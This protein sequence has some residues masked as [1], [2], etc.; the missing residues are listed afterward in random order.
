MVRHQQLGGGEEE[1]G[2]GGVMVRH[3][4]FGGGGGRWS[5]SISGKTTDVAISAKRKVKRFDS[6]QP[7]PTSQTDNSVFKRALS[8]KTSN[9]AN[10]H[11][12]VDLRQVLK[13]Q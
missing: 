13:I 6:N 8:K 9:Q 1:G 2:G 11:F 3:H 5:E 10:I 4:Q 7:L 12:V